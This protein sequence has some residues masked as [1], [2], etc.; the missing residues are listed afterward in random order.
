MHIRILA[1]AAAAALA[2]SFFSGPVA[3]HGVALDAGLYSQYRLDGSGTIGFIVCGQLNVSHGG[4]Y[5][6][7]VLGKFEHAC[8]VLDGEPRTNWNKSVITR[9]IY[10]LDK[11][12][13]SGDAPLLYVFKRKDTISETYDDVSVTLVTK[14]ELPMSGGAA[15]QCFSAANAAAVYVG[16]DLGPSAVSISKST[17]DVQSV[18]PQP[19]TSIT[20]DDRGFVSVSGHDGSL[21][22]DP[23]GVAVATGNGNSTVI[24]T[25]NAWNP[26][27]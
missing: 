19:V 11:R 24:S 16:T 12:T 21:V 14:I 18:L 5:S 1:A 3:A 27:Q 15:A 2:F 20:A 6:T 23:T 22:F 13:S 17:F 7:P 10:V 26:N 8:A 4:C 9:A 25:R